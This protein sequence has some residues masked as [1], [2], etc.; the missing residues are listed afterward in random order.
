MILNIPYQNTT[1]KFILDYFNS[2]CQQLSNVN[3]AV[4]LDS[5]EAKDTNKIYLFITKNNHVYLFCALSC[6]NTDTNKYEA[7]ET[8]WVELDN[9]EILDRHKN[10]ESVYLFDLKKFFSTMSF[11]TNYKDR[12][13][14]HLYESGENLAYKISETINVDIATNVKGVL[15]DRI[16][17]QFFIDML[18]KLRY[19]YSLGDLPLS[20]SSSSSGIYPFGHKVMSVR[21]VDKNSFLLPYFNHKE[22]LNFAVALS[23]CKAYIFNDGTYN[24]IITMN[25]SKTSLY[26]AY[27]ILRNDK[28][29]VY[30]K[31]NNIISLST[32][33]WLMFVTLQNNKIWSNANVYTN[34]TD[35]IFKDKTVY[36]FF[37]SYIDDNLS[38]E[39]KLAAN[40][41]F[42]RINENKDTTDC[43]WLKGFSWLQ[44]Y[45]YVGKLKAE[46]IF[47]LNKL[48]TNAKNSYFDF[49]RQK[50]VG[51]G[52]VFDDKKNEDNGSKRT[53]IDFTYKYDSDLPLKISFTELKHYIG[54]DLSQKTFI[55]RFYTNGTDVVI[56]KLDKDESILDSLIVFN[57]TMSKTY[58]GL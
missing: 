50:F 35:V 21:N 26:I 4:D 41:E 28:F 58:L 2:C 34:H 36:H 51:Y 24:Y 43:E 39:E 9:V 47:T 10:T 37:N 55:L 8:I 23:D 57:H 53:E 32:G 15:Y 49:S 3:F 56:E 12:D 22:C 44:N 45:A 48:F 40:V 38:T 19:D 18:D 13:L 1:N 33:M 16:I 11:A 6:K 14:I 25:N 5:D 7:I 42:I 46:E 20:S 54:T 31:D 17:K 29:D 52:Y 27:N 30:N